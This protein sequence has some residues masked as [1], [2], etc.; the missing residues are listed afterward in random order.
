LN[1]LLDSSLF[2]PREPLGTDQTDIRIVTNHLLD[3]IESPTI[4]L[5]RKGEVVARNRPSLGLVYSAGPEW[6]VRELPHGLSIASHQPP[7]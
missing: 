7:A 1:Q 5:N 6:L 4:V 2:E 3:K